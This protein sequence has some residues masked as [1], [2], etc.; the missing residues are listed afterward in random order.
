M[1]LKHTL[2]AIVAGGKVDGV[3][4]KLGKTSKEQSPE[5]NTEGLPGLIYLKAAAFC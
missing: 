1:W 3:G 2:E 5:S 4:K